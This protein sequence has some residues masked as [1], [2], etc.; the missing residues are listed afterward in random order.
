[1]W[2]LSDICTVHI[3]Y[4]MEKLGEEEETYLDVVIKYFN[5]NG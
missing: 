1:M 2:L 5:L 3:L 4:D